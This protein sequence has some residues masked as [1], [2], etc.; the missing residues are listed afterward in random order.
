MK[1]LVFAIT[2]MAVL[3]SGYWF[4]QAYSLRSGIEGW[5]DARRA[6]GWAA[7]YSDMSVRGFPNRLDVTFTDL[8]LANPETKTAWDA[9]MFQMLSLVYNPGH[10][11]FAFAE[12]QS[13]STP[14]GAY[15]IT[16]D[17]LR[18]SLV[19][20]GDRILRGNLEAQVLNIAGPVDL[21]MAGLTFGIAADE[22]KPERLRIGLNAAAIAGSQGALAPALSD[23]IDEIAL[24]AE[25]TFDQIWTKDA[26]KT[27]KPQPR[28]IKLPLAEYRADDLELKATADWDV[29][30]KGRLDGSATLRAVNWRALLDEAKGAGDLPSGVADVLTETLGVIAGLSGNKKALDL[31]FTFNE[32]RVALGILPLGNAP[33]IRF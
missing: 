3:W 12:D 26:L 19:T 11:I 6:D 31:K 16:S 13:L 29:D 33:R 5:F 14:E 32:G 25:I 15:Q 8:T 22:T 18:A 4:V 20:E 10:W 9:P 27:G 1:R 24:Q 2:A 28:K 23:K 21:A 7:E 17:G 30:T